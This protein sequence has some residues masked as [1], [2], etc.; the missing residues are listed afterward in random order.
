MTWQ[1]ARPGTTRHHGR[2]LEAEP[3]SGGEG[4]KRKITE[5]L[6]WQSCSLYTL[7]CAAVVQVLQRVEEGL[8]RVLATEPG[9]S[10][11]FV[12][13]MKS[14]FFDP[15]VQQEDIIEYIRRRYVLLLHLLR[16]DVDWGR[17][18]AYYREISSSCTCLDRPRPD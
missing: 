10:G 12:G 13:G 15:E 18:G 14:V 5:H 3:R 1:A 11:N 6:G 4:R 7:T 17:S 8:G 2:A 9:M 16:C